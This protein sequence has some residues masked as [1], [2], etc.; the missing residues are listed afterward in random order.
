MRARARL[1]D[2]SS[3]FSWLAPAA[4]ALG[5][6]ACSSDMERFADKPTEGSDSI[7]TS[8]VPKS[9]QTAQAEDS[10]VSSR[11]LSNSTIKPRAGS[12]SNAY[13]YQNSY[14]QPPYK[15]SSIQENT[16]QS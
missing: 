1:S 7:Y 10:S 5:L 4:V 8:S 3:K 2:V 12:A 14:K 6:S 13:T 16:L 15:Q 11:P 9:V